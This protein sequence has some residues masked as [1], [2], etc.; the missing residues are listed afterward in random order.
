[1]TAREPF[2]LRAHV[3]A[4]HPDLEALAAAGCPTCAEAVAQTPM[5]PSNVLYGGGGRWFYLGHDVT[6]APLAWRCAQGHSW[7][8]TLAVRTGP[9][10]PG[11]PV[12]AKGATS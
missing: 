12:C 9:N 8:E 4:E 5:T 1:M 7:R 2:D 6:D 11:C 10:D 3:E